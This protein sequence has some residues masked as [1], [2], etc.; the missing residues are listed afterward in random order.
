MS[1]LELQPGS[2]ACMVNTEIGAVLAVMRRNVRWG[3][4]FTSVDD[5]QEHSLVQSLKT[6]RKKMFTWHAQWHSVNPVMYLQPF[7]DVIQSEETGAPITSVALSSVYKI[8]MLDMFDMNTIGIHNTM[9]LIVD[10]VTNCHFEVTDPTSEEV[11]LMKIL[12]VLLA[13]VKSKVSV[14][15]SNQHICNIVDTCFRVVQ[16]TSAKS[17]LLQRIARHSMHELVRSIFSRLPEV[18]STCYK[19]AG[20]GNLTNDEVLN[21]FSFSHLNALSKKFFCHLRI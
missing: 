11:V 15:L 5:Q 13:C 9:H 17:E 8:L 21:C 14:A 12:Q 2:L 19:H 1:C 4:R 10:S 3:N 18:D 20:G 6:L 7:L 16:Q